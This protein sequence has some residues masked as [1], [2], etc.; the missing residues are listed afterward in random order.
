MG[1]A[2]T[3]ELFLERL[4]Q[5]LPAPARLEPLL[6]RM[7]AAPSRRHMEL[8]R[9]GGHHVG[10]SPLAPGDRLGGPRAGG[11]SGPLRRSACGS[12]P[13]RAIDATAIHSSAAASAG[14]ATALPRRSPMP[15][16][17]PPWRASRSASPASG[18]STTPP[19]V[20]STPKPFPV[21]PAGPVCGF[22]HSGGQPF[23]GRPHS[24]AMAAA[25]ELLAVWRGA[26]AAGGGR[27]P[28]AGGCHQP[29]G[30]RASAAAQGPAGQALCPAG[31]GGQL[32]HPLVPHR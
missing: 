10:R 16:P 17:T 6:P 24:A 29:R 12:W 28:A 32:D 23:G 18:N 19:T 11:R 31:G 26:G 21:P 30:D 9:P 15:G 5:R 3:L 4:P 13:I 22:E 2:G 1:P 20:A 27:L 14:R 7:A 25:C 8:D